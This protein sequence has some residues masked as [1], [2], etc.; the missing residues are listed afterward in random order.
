MQ[1]DDCLFPFRLAHISSSYGYNQNL[2]QG[3]YGVTGSGSYQ[4]PWYTVS[5]LVMNT[6]T[7]Y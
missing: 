1:N 4:P 3:Y 7:T 6:L 2:Y 5:Q